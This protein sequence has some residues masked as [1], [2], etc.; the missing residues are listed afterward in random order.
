VLRKNRNRKQRKNRDA[1]VSHSGSVFLC[2]P[3]PLL[4]SS[5]HILSLSSHRTLSRRTPVVGRRRK[6]SASGG[7]PRECEHLPTPSAH[8]V[9]AVCEGRRGGTDGCCACTPLVVWPGNPC[10][11]TRRVCS[12]T[13]VCI[14]EETRAPSV[15]SSSSAQRENALGALALAYSV[16]RK[17]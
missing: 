16:C 12:P 1:P 7:L 14:A 2:P 8:V 9:V 5:F 4:R 15:E 3:R 13:S 10:V 11:G 17:L 6:L